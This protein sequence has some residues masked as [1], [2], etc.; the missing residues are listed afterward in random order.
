MDESVDLA[1]MPVKLPD[2]ALIT[3]ITVSDF[4]TRDYLHNHRIA[5]GSPILLAGYFYQFPGER[6]FEPIIRQGVLAMIPDEPMITT[7]GKPGTMYLGEVHI[8]GGN[9]GSPVMVS[10]DWLGVG[11]YHLLGVVS[12][13]YFENEDFSLEIATTVKGIEHAN[14]GIT[15]IV[16]VDLL[17]S[18]L[19]A[20]RLREARDHYFLQ[21]SNTAK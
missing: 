5:E 17:K 10:P 7:T 14:S 20:P 4:A 11:G 8:F 21:N 6:R 19:D 2:S 13:Y 3:L 12:G 18:L 15:M 9:S 16:P 1:A